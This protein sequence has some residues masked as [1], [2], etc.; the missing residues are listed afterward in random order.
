MAICE[1]YFGNS[2]DPFVFKDYRSQETCPKLS[3]VLP[4]HKQQNLWGEKKLGY[5]VENHCLIR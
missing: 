5:S 2:S 1:N 3:A 4:G